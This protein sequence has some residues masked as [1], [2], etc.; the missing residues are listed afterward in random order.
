MGL[1]GAKVLYVEDVY[2]HQ[3]LMKNYLES[4]KVHCETVSSGEE[5]LEVIKTNNY[6]LVIMDIQ[7]PGLNGYETSLKIRDYNDH[8][9][10]IPI[11]AF[12]ADNSELSQT[13]M[14]EA[15][16]NGILY[17]PLDAEKLSHTLEEQ[18]NYRTGFTI[19]GIEYYRNAFNNSEK[20]NEFISL[21]IQDL[22]KF[23]IDFDS[24]TVGDDT[25][26]LKKELHK[27]KPFI[28]QINQGNLKELFEQYKSKDFD[29]QEITTL[30]K[31][32]IH[33]LKELKIGWKKSK[34]QY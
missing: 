12:T 29:S 21:F 32:L 23:I 9:S 19:T 7:M 10:R 27:L 17:K 20:F 30:N 8:Y 1:A 24:F 6:D 26:L 16:M 4:I 28:I 15:K 31:K 2:T 5:A 14:R 13:K 22:D 33:E 34:I 3:F 11:V 25:T 18:L